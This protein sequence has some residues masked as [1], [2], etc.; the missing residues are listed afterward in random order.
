M[1][2]AIIHSDKPFEL[3]PNGKG[4]NNLNQIQDLGII[5]SDHNQIISLTNA[6]SLE[7]VVVGI[8]IVGE[9]HL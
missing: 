1:V 7:V 5:V 4:P 6:G 2:S 8:A 9:S 3:V